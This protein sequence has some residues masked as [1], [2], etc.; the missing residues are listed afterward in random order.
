MIESTPPPR[1]ITTKATTI[2][3]TPTAATRT[4]TFKISSH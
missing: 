3:T 1:A 4:I 2:L